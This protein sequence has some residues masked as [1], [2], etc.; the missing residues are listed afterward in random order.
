MKLILLLAFLGSSMFAHNTPG[1]LSN[2][3]T[4]LTRQALANPIKVRY[5]NYR[6]ETAVR[7]IVPIRFYFGKTEYHPREQ[8]LI[9]LWDVDRD[10]LR[11][12]ALAEITQWFVE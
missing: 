4:G 12:Y 11:V 10:A 8:W 3:P 6:G 2:L 1:N 7:T 9:E 5:T